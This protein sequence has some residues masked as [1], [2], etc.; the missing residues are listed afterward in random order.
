MDKIIE[1]KQ[2]RSILLIGMLL[3]LLVFVA[4]Y[5]YS[6]YSSE[7]FS[8]LL[9]LL[10]ICFIVFLTISFID[11]YFVRVTLT[12]NAIIK[13]SLLINKVIEIDK[14]TEA[15]VLKF[16]NSIIV[17]TK[18]KR[19][20]IGWDY[21]RTQEFKKLLIKELEKRDTSIIYKNEWFW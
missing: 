2:K 6:F 11:G 15:R 19:L 10:L 20:G 17:N 21:E 3:L 12:E 8:L 16:H 14:I 13:K 18:D 7:E 1:I 9:H 4:P 5:S